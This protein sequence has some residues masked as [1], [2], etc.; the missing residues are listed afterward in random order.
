MF[1]ELGVSTLDELNKLSFEKRKVTMYARDN[2]NY[3][4]SFPK[5]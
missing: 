1:S 4:I 5:K 2:I 3:G